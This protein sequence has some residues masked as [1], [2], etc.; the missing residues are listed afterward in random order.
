[1]QALAY[2]LGIGEAVMVPISIVLLATAVAAPSPMRTAVAVALAILLASTVAQPF[3]VVAERKQAPPP[4]ARLVS[5]TGV[6]LDRA[7][8]TIPVMPFALY[9]E[10]SLVAGE[11]AHRP[12]SRRALGSGSRC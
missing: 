9:R 12:R 4:H 1:M 11:N 2:A 10:Q 5:A 7:F 8:G 3:G 6:H